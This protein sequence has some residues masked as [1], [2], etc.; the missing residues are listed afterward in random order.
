MQTV[1]FQITGHFILKNGLGRSIYLSTLREVELMRRYIALLSLLALGACTTVPGAISDTTRVGTTAVDSAV[2]VATGVLN[3]VFNV[4]NNAANDVVGTTNN[5][6][7]AVMPP[8]A[9]PPP[10]PYRRY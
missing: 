2:A 4:V 7:A 3:T 5:V 9:P 1:P 10:P 6:G 8:P